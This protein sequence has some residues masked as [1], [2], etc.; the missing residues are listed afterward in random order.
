MPSSAMKKEL[1]TL[2]NMKN[3]K[4]KN[5]INSNFLSSPK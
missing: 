1:K 3:K 5:E 4:N 2:R